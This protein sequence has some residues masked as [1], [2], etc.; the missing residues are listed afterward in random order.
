V[1]LVVNPELS[2]L[3]DAVKIK[4]LTEMVGGAVGGVILNRASTEKTML[5]SQKIGQIMGAEVLEV[6]P[7]DSGV[8][9]AA[10]FKTPVVVMYPDSPAAKGFKRLAARIAG[11]TAAVVE[12]A[13]GKKET[14]IDRLARSIFGGV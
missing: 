12:S 4:V 14:F 5:T 7:E 9:R 1:L 10:A 2:S 13:E 6:I 3:A 8:R 11:S